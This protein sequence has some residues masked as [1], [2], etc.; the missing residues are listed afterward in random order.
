MFKLFLISAIPRAEN[1]RADEL[2]KLASGTRKT[3][4]VK[5]KKNHQCYTWF[6]DHEV[7]ASQVEITPE[8]DIL[9]GDWRHP[10]IEYLTKGTTPS[11]RKSRRN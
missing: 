7:M 3:G 11:D 2:A 8:E 9:P 10:I 4:I 1:A 6:H 5:K